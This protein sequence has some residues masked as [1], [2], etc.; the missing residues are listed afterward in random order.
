MFRI[1]LCVGTVTWVGGQ[2]PELAHG[3]CEMF[4]FLFKENSPSRPPKKCNMWLCWVFVVALR[5]FSCCMWDLVPW[6]GME[7][8][9][10]PCEC[11]VLATGPPEKSPFEFLNT[12]VPPCPS[13]RSVFEKQSWSLSCLVTC[14][15]WFLSTI[16]TAPTLYWNHPANWGAVWS[17]LVS[18][19][20]LPCPV[21]KSWNNWSCDGPQDSSFLTC[22]LWG[23]KTASRNDHRFE[24][25][26]L[27]T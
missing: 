1:H 22:E 14:Q 13:C 10:L 8:G 3:D 24:K 26:I 6:L 4:F 11:R 19:L 12:R 25:R 2:A 23:G 7:P 17:F 18:P 15:N 16:L 9:P 27:G 5:I 21:F 20:P